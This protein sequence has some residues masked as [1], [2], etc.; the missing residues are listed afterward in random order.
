[1]MSRL[2]TC[3]LSCSLSTAPRNRVS[4]T[5]RR[6]ELGLQFGRGAQRAPIV[7]AGA[8]C[9]LTVHAGPLTVHAGRLTLYAGHL[10]VYAGHLTVRAGHLTVCAGHLTVRAGRLTLHAGRFTVHAGRFTVRAGR[11]TVRAGRFTV[12]AGRFTVRAG[13]LT[14]HAGRLPVHAGRCA[15]R[16]GGFTV[17]AGGF[18][19]RAGVSQCTPAVAQCAMGVA[20]VETAASRCPT[21]THG[22]SHL[23]PVPCDLDQCTVSSP[24]DIGFANK[25]PCTNDTP[26]ALTA[27]KS[28]VFSTP[29]AITRAP[30][31]RA[32]S[33]IELMTAPRLG[34][35][36][37]PATE[38]RAR[39]RNSGEASSSILKFDWPRPTSS[40]AIDA[41]SW[42][43]EA[44]ARWNASLSHGGACSTIS[45]VTRDGATC[46]SRHVVARNS[47]NDGSR[48]SVD[49]CTLMLMRTSSPR[50]GRLRSATAMQ[51]RSTTISCRLRRT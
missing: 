33:S 12:R 41:P 42:R 15:V 40:R 28:S 31:R 36:A 39:L 21:D 13:R 34:A 9:D 17:R 11:F 10:T 30:K 49:A 22:S 4:I 23:S 5:A 29:S 25:N 47:V 48:P 51:A 19:V 43:S 37:Q 16:A 44:S 27:C 35:C 20:R 50:C 8:R 45:T 32:S 1:M 26:I 6:R 46:V 14:V 3:H 24:A 7:R 38:E 18:T 2:P